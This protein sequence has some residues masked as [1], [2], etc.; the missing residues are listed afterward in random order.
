MRENIVS[1]LKDLGLSEYE[2]RAYL[3]LTT[4]G[5][6]PASSVSSFSRIPQ[7]KIYEVLKSLNTKSLAD[8]WIGSSQYRAV[9]PR[10][11]EKLLTKG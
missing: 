6:L 10:L 2:A 5:P 11:P 3:A 7:S 8:F 1:D 9:E 4:H